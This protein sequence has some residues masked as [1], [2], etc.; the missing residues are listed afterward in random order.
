MPDSATVFTEDSNVAKLTY[1]SGRLY[2]LASAF[3]LAHPYGYPQIMSSFHFSE[4]DQGAF[5][6]TQFSSQ[7]V[8]E[9]KG[10][11]WSSL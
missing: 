11:T 5:A 2:Q 6:S 10:T 1:K 3:M 8:P 4:Y 7:Q 9:R